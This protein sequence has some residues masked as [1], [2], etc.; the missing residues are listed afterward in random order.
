MKIDFILV[1]MIF[2]FLLVIGVVFVIFVKNINSSSQ[3]KQLQTQISKIKQQIESFQTKYQAL[4]GDISNA[5][6][7]KLSNYPT[8]GNADGIINDS[9]T[10]NTLFDGELTNFWLH[11]SGFN[12]FSEQYDGFSNESARIGFSL[13]KAKTTNVGIVAFGTK[14]NNKSMNFLH[15]GF[16]EADALNLYTKPAIKANNARI[17]DQKLDDGL[18]NYGNITAKTGKTLKDNSDAE[19]CW[20]NNNYLIN[21]NE[22]SC[23]L[24]FSF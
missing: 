5:F 9:I 14:Q 3:V 12:I 10:E 21:N 6:E 22:I 8:N 17:I 23:Q 19:K 16:S 15:I 13:P 2:I 11:L 24:L 1:K 7:L 18:P 20:R 4:P